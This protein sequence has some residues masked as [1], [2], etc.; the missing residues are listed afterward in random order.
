M[1]LDHSFNGLWSA[2]RWHHAYE[3]FFVYLE[4]T[5]PGKDWHDG[6]GLDSWRRTLR[7]TLL[8]RCGTPQAAAGAA[9]SSGACGR[10]G[11]PALS[12]AGSAALRPSRA[13]FDPQGAVSPAFGWRLIPCGAHAAVPT[14]NTKPAPRAA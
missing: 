5:V 2:L 7:L 12:S 9:I 4:R 6:S 14:Q 13:L 8:H 10:R 3:T 11:N 1:V